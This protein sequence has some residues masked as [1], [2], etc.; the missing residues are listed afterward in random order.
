[1]LV[2]TKT[3]KFDEKNIENFCYYSDTDSIIVGQKAYEKLIELGHVG[4][5]LGQIKLEHF[6]QPGTFESYGKKIYRF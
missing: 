1:M 4:K 6:I 3:Y 2:K 5:D